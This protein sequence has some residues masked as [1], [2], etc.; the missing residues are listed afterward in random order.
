MPGIALGCPVGNVCHYHNRDAQVSG[1]DRDT[2]G[3]LSETPSPNVPPGWPQRVYGRDDRPATIQHPHSGVTGLQAQGALKEGGKQEGTEGEG[4]ETAYL[5]NTIRD[6]A[7][8]RGC[9]L[10]LF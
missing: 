2:G 9:L 10:F 7:H 6:R 5:Q 4:F 1:L 8:G 3:P